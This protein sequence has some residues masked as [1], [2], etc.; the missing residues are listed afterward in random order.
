MK[1]K[2][3]PLT[4]EQADYAADHHN[5][6]YKFLYTNH[7][8]VDD[9][10]DVAVFGYLRAVRNYLTREDLRAYKF[11]TIAWRSMSSEMK[12][13]FRASHAQMRDGVTIPFDEHAD[14]IISLRAYNDDYADNIAA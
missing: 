3:I 10:Y 13:H 11:T 6:I 14:N 4:E 5:L 12:N 2:D 9:F 7:Y 8:K 1:A